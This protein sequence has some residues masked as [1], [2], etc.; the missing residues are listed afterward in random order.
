MAPQR[1]RKSVIQRKLDTQLAFFLRVRG[2]LAGTSSSGASARSPCRSPEL[3]LRLLNGETVGPVPRAPCGSPPPSA[4]FRSII[5][6][7][8]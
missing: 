2:I 7:P 1:R 3:G 8:L 6:D 4:S 5:K